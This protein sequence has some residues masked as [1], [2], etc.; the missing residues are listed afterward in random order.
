MPEVPVDQRFTAEVCGYLAGMDQAVAA[1][2]EFVFLA[3]IEDAL[4]GS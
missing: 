1:A 3:E 4:S 2:C